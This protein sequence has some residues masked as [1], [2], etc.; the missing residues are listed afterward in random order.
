MPSMYLVTWQWPACVPES[1]HMH[2]TLVWDECSSLVAQG[3]VNVWV[4]PA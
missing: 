3:A 2:R 4:T 1:V